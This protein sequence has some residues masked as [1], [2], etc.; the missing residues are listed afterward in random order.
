MYVSVRVSVRVSL[1]VCVSLCVSV[2]VCVCACVRVCVSFL[3]VSKVLVSKTGKKKTNLA[4]HF[5]PHDLRR[6]MC[7][8]CLAMP[9]DADVVAL[10][11]QAGSIVTIHSD[12]SMRVRMMPVGIAVF[13]PHPIDGH[14]IS[15]PRQLCACSIAYVPL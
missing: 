11:A 15:C 3:E 5:E 7:S 1:C 6:A 14:T 4:R 2:C 8:C 9:V 12:R 10:A 13:C